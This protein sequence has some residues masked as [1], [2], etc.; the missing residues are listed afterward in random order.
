MRFLDLLEKFLMYSN[1][2]FCFCLNSD[3]FELFFGNEATISTLICLSII[4]LTNSLTFFLC[5]KPKS[6]SFSLNTI[7]SLVLLTW[8]FFYF[9]N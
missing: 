9:N 6:T 4:A 8:L 1:L 3:S 5:L 2:D 7:T